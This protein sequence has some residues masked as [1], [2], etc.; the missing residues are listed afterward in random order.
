M[1]IN[2]DI[3]HLGITS[4]RSEY[5]RFGIKTDDRR[6]HVYVIGKAGVGKT[7]LIENMA[8]FDI[9]NNKGLGIIDPHGELSSKI[10]NFIPE[11]RIKDVIYFNP[12]DIDWPITF[13]VIEEVLP[14]Y[15]YLVVSGLMGVFKKIWPDVWSARMEYILSNTLLALLEY[16]DATLLCVN[17]MLADKDFRKS[18][19]DRITDP[20]LKSFWEKEFSSYH[21]KFAIEAIAPIQNKVGQFISNP[22]I[23]GIIGQKKSKLD[24]RKIMDEGKILI[25]NLS[26]GLIGEDNCALLGSLLVTKLQLAAMSRVNIPEQERKDFYLYIDE[27]QTFATSSFATILAEARK[28]RLNLILAHQY[29]AQLDEKVRDAIFGNI[30]TL[31]VYRVGPKDAEFLE[32]HLTPTFTISDIINLPNFNYYIKLMIDGLMSPAFSAINLPPMSLPQESWTQEV[33]HH[34]RDNYSSPKEEIEKEIKKWQLLD[35]APENNKKNDRQKDKRE[36]TEAWQ[37][38]C[39]SCQKNA[40]VYF[41]PDDKRPVYCPDCLE[42]IRRKEMN[43]VEKKFSKQSSIKAFS[44]KEITSQDNITFSGKNKETNSQV[45]IKDKEKIDEENLQKTI[46]NMFKEVDN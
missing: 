11:S 15:R 33:I 30:G 22:L 16:P 21:D 27:F 3:S 7:T 1:Q 40:L 19:V 34:S 45:E 6:R 26:K 18:V 44:L 36:K 13:N 17:R 8:I 41:K 31:I 25:V 12:S 35:F 10:L 28:Y 5:Q 4:F 29:I 14:E 32:S 20:I 9:S 23:R 39:D 46:E 42:K 2:K 37:V 38:I 24:F 43:P